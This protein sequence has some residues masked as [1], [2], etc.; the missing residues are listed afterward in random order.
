[1]RREA[2]HMTYGGCPEGHPHRSSTEGACEGKKVEIALQAVRLRRTVRTNELIIKIFMESFHK[3]LKLI[4]KIKVSFYDQTTN[5]FIFFDS[6][7]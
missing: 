5:F 1:V 7:I 4:F 3:N 6:K 2:P